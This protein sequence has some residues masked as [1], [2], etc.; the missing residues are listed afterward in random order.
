MNH[1]TFITGLAR[2]F[3]K[4]TDE[5]S[6][7][8]SSLTEIIKDACCDLDS[9]AIPGFGRF[10]TVKKEEYVAVDPSDGVK[11]LFPPSLS[12]NF[13]AGSMLKKRLGHE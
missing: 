5:V 12:V 1:N 3:G 4:N 8:T 13:V 10:E 6:R 11:K 7:L 2:Q 9:I